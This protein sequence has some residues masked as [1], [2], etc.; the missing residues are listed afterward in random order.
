[1]NWT[2]RPLLG[3]DLETTDAN[4]MVA[5]P[6]S[7]AMVLRRDWRRMSIDHTTIDPGCEIPEE[8]TA[9]HGISTERARREGVPLM[10]AMHHIKGK[11]FWAQREQIPVVGHNV[12]Y[13]LTIVHRY[14]DL[15]EF[16]GTVMDTFVLD[17]AID[18]WRPGS[19][20]LGALAEHLGV[21]APEGMP[22]HE[23]RSDAVGSIL[24]LLSMAQRWPWLAAKTPEQHHRY[25][26]RWY[27]QQQA[28]LS[29]HFVSQGKEPIPLS[30]YGWPIKR[31]ALALL[32]EEGC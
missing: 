13:D 22:L 27:E 24:T 23:A 17:K 14:T 6:C 10:A 4:P 12:S 32:E 20:K 19:R 21:T 3:L 5:V 11:L 25:Q 29:E 1:M 7:Y 15:S 31:G 9:I 18:K 16:T 30:E 26:E 8:A 28:D 2:D